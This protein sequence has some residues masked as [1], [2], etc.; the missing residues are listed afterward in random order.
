M[1][2]VV[3]T[4]LIAGFLFYYVSFRAWDERRAW[5]AVGAYVAAM[6]C[7]LLAGMAVLST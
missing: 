1:T 5:E 3:G 4:L 2:G 6:A 7:C